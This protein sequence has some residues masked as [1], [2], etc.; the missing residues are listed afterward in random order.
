MNDITDIKDIK[1]QTNV[2]LVI[3][4]KYKNYELLDI[5]TIREISGNI[6]IFIN[7]VIDFID[8]ELIN[9]TDKIG[10]KDIKYF[11]SEKNEKWVEELNKDPNRNVLGGYTVG[12]VEYDYS[13]LKEKYYA[14]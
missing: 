9:R 2:F 3:D 11:I 12:K 13:Y 5:S 14:N 4:T 8:N 1:L 10:N 6:E 7:S